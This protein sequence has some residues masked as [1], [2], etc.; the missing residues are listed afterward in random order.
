MSIKWKPEYS[1]KVKEI[2]EQHQKLVILIDKLYVAINEN[3]GNKILGNI[4]DDLIDFG[5]YHFATE[6]KYFDMFK[7]KFAN[8]HKKIHRGF[9]V[10]LGDFKKKFKNN[11]LEI[12]FE[13]IDFLEDWLLDH[14]IT[15]DQKYV[16]CFIDNGLK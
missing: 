5:V 13:L 1:V 16:Q 12:S 15:T 3:K 6:E 7:Y 2:D 11:E 8:E 4:L 9:E 10:K 14:L